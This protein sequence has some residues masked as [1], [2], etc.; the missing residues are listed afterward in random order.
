MKDKRELCDYIGCGRRCVVCFELNW[1]EQM[2][3]KDGRQTSRRGSYSLPSAMTR[4]LYSCRSH[5]SEFHK[6]IKKGLMPVSDS[7]GLQ[8]GVHL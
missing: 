7:K 1:L 2:Q 3:Y 6:L 8:V 5:M 4:R